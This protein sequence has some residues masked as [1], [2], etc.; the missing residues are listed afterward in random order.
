[1]QLRH[2]VLVHHDNARPAAEKKPARQ[3]QLSQPLQ[4]PMG[5]PAACTANAVGPA[6]PQPHLAS[7]FEE[8]RS[9]HLLVGDTAEHEHGEQLH[10]HSRLDGRHVGSGQRGQHR[11]RRHGAPPVEA[12]LEARVARRPRAARPAA[13]PESLLAGANRLHLEG[14]NRGWTDPPLVTRGLVKTT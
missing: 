4:L 9:A 11:V 5:C 13:C 12:R 2:D 8:P 1:M 10:G 3:R 6:G 14:Q 7:L